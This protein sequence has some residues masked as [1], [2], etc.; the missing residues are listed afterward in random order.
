[1]AMV[2]VA[3]TQSGLIAVGSTD[4]DRGTPVLVFLTGALAG[5]FTDRVMRRLRRL[6]GATKTDERASEQPPPETA[7]TPSTAAPGSLTPS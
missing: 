7:A 4:A 3:A 5:L 2:F 6:L 1:V